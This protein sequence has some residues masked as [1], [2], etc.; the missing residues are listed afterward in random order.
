MLTYNLDISKKSLWLRTTPG[1][2]ALAQPYYVTEAGLFYARK[3]FETA[4]THK[5]SF[6]V[7][8]TF[9][10]KGTLR[11]ED[12]TVT[13]TPG[14]ALMIDC[15]IPQKYSTAPDSD[16]WDH[17]WVH[18]D[19]PGVSAIMEAISSSG[20]MAGP[21]QVPESIRD[22]FD[23]LLLRI[24][25]ETTSAVL[26]SS[27]DLHRIL[28]YLASGTLHDTTYSQAGHKELME[29]AAEY[30]REHYAQELHLEELLGI[31]NISRSY[32][33]R[34]FQQYMGTTPYNFLIRT[35]ITQ[36]K[37]LLEMTDLP[38]SIVA[39]RVGFGN[40][41]NFSSRFRQVVGIT[42]GQYRRQAIRGSQVY[43]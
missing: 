3:G 15:R 28:Q 38:V 11:Q 20:M 26:S 9:S 2:T 6:L 14:T 5:N 25:Q 33:L 21:V 19:G 16:H 29:R 22:T 31:T 24:S 10:G 12:A 18:T 4:R 35:R 39:E 41:T 40:E 7:F 23:H 42:P 37:E 1:Q 32:F 34:L 13:L 27:L 30:I 17:Y 36:A 43:E 8:Y